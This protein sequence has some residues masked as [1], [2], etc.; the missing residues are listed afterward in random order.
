MSAYHNGIFPWF[1][2]GEPILWW[3][4]DP[5]GVLFLDNL[6]ISRS[7]KKSIRKQ[8]FTF[9][10]NQSFAAVIEQCATQR[11]AQEGTWITS[12]MKTA[13]TQLHQQHNAFSIEVWQAQQLVGGLYG[14]L[15]G[16]VFCGE[17]MFHTVTDASKAALCFLVH[18]CKQSGVELIDCQMQNEHLAS[19]GVS[20][21]SRATFLEKLNQ[22][23]P[24][25]IN[26]SLWFEQ[27]HE[28]FNP[29]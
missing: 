29:N 5:R 9:S 18:L 15:A 28:S 11:A 13:Y 20:E 7:L 3:S 22:L 1:N 12:Q 23:T 26:K 4:P 24:K 8:G 6:H 21:I 27:I 19:L 25:M 17:S 14:V 10:V 2:P 16:G